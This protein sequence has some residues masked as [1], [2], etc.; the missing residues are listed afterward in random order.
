VCA[1]HLQSHAGTAGH[2]RQ[3]IVLQRLE[4]CPCSNLCVCTFAGTTPTYLVLWLCRNRTRHGNNRSAWTRQ[5]P[6]RWYGVPKVAY[7]ST[8]RAYNDMT[9]AAIVESMWSAA[10]NRLL[11]T[12]PR[13]LIEST[14]AMPGK[15]GGR[16]ARLPLMPRATNNISRVL[17]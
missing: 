8:L 10:V 7:H 15:V 17:V 13:A 6:E 4:Y 12:T 3:R 1:G 9:Q 16:T 5:L 2:Q 14:R 11:T